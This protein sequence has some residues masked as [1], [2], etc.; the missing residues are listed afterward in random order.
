MA[1][2]IANVKNNC[3]FGVI[4]LCNNNINFSIHTL[5]YTNS[6]M[7]VTL[8]IKLKKTNKIYHEGVS[9]WN[10]FLSPDSAG[11]FIMIVILLDPVMI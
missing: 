4:I 9:T 3:Q 1:T 6:T 2:F 11:G 7:S 8:D 5:F 10:H